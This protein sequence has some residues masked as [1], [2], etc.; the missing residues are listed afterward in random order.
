MGITATLILLVAFFWKPLRAI[1]KRMKSF[2]RL[3]DTWNGIEEV[4]D[5]SGAVTQDAVPGILARL[6]SVET[7]TS[8][9]DG[10]ESQIERI[11]HEVTPNHGGS[12]KDEVKR[13]ETA[14]TKTASALS[15]TVEKLD[16]HIVIA[17][18]SDKAQ[19]QLVKDLGTLKSKYAP[20]V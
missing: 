7:S 1:W 2:A 12:I 19:E 5:K 6:I 9:I 8:K 18:E 11:H 20:E 17:K 14:V 13:I 3:L 16:E 15:E 10:L 4:R